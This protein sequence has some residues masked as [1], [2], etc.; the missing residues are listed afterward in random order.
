MPASEPAAR[1]A[2]RPTLKD[3]AAET[4][5]SVTAVSYALRGLHG[6]ESTRRRVVEA[7]ARLGYEADPI[8]RALASGS[9]G[10]TG[11]LCGSLTD[12]WQQR[13]AAALARA[14]FA[15]GVNALIVDAAGDPGHQLE[16]AERVVQQ[17]VDAL[18]VIPLDPLTA[19]WEPIGD[20]VPLI[21][22]GDELVAAH[23]ASAVLFDVGLAVTHAL[24]TLAQHGH[25]RVSVLAAEM[26]SRRRRP[27][28]VA[29]AKLARARGLTLTVTTCPHE[30]DGARAAVA[31]LLGADEPPTAV[32]GLADSMAY[33]AYAAARELGLDIPSDLSVIGFDDHPMS[34]LLTPA[35][36]SY[37]W[38]LESIVE[39]IMH[40]VSLTVSGAASVDDVLLAPEPFAR[41]SV[42]DA[43]SAS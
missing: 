9:T 18:V 42:G 2:K 23:T 19:G 8:A 38:P 30:L 32:L 26:S 40:R 20:R 31:A 25:H 10:V 35:L 29:A 6:K 17:R 22:V 37:R 41:G 28:E 34:A 3:V 39:E 14:L 15:D 4:G 1:P 16:L 43:P 7:A 27:I 11:V 12:L 5:L 24:D 13:L 33:G 36:S 21:T